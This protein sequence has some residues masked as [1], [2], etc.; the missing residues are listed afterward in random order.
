M[1]KAKCPICEEKIL[2]NEKVKFLDRVSCPT[3][4]ALLEVV[5]TS[6]V[7]LDWIYFDEDSNNNGKERHQKS[8]SARC[9]LCHENVHIGKNMKVGNQVI[10][11]GC[12]AQLE[13]VSLVPLEL[14]WPF[15]GGGYDYY[16]QDDDYYEE[17]YD[18]HRN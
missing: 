6:P 5:N 12:D 16:S 13:I 18:E 11:T 2:L 14:D 17:S 8:G 15:G 9:P 1:N 3:C 7:E 10:C 4:D